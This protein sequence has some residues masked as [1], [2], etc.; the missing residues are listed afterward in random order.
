MFTSVTGAAARRVAA[1][2][3]ITLTIRRF[4]VSR[5]TRQATKAAIATATKKERLNPQMVI[6]VEKTTAS[7]KP[8]KK[9]TAKKPAAKK[10]PA[11]KKKPVAKKKKVVKPK[12]AKK[13]IRKMGVLSP[14][15]L[16]RVKIAGLRKTALLSQQPKLKAV[17]SW[18]CFMVENTK[19]VEQGD[20]KSTDRVVQLKHEW[21]AMSDS[22]KEVCYAL[23]IYQYKTT[24]LTILCSLTLPELL[25]TGPKTP[26][27]C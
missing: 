21:T 18:A 2:R 13:P 5:W 7:G 23:Y 17:N 20:I 19:N 11:V 25:R 26:R 22:Q 8:V 4:T 10:K 12:K 27:P 16:E 1:S 9:P 15:K 24:I 3:P 14:E 6:P